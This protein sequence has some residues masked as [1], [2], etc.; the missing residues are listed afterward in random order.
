MLNAAVRLG[1][2]GSMAGKELRAELEQ[3]LGALAIHTEV[4]EHPEVFTV[5]EM[6]PHVQHLK[7]AHSTFLLASPNLITAD[8]EQIVIGRL[9]EDI[10][11]PCSFESEPE[12]VIHW[13]NQDSYVHSYYKGSDHLEAQDHRYTN[14]TSLFHG[15]MHK[16]NASL[17]LRRL[18]L[19]DEGIYLCYVGTTSRT[20]INKVVLKVGAFITPMMKYEKRN[21]E[22]FLICC[23]SSYPHPHISWKMENTT[24]SESNKGEIETLDPL[25]VDSMIN[26]T[27]S[28]LSYECGIENSLLNQTWI[29]RWTLKDDLHK[30]QS[31]DFSLSCELTNSIFLLDQDFIVTWSKVE[32]ETSSIL[33]YFLS[34]SQNTIINEPRVSWNKELINQS[35]FFLTLK[36]L[37]VSDSGE[38]LCNISSSKYT[39]LT[40]QTL[41]VVEQRQSRTTWI[42][43]LSFVI[44]A[45]CI[46]YML[47][48]YKH[49]RRE[50]SSVYTERANTADAEESKAFTEHPASSGK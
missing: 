11:L 32:R 29:G 47:K 33:A 21:T 31:E 35:D 48:R 24:I 13:K 1:H 41:H 22:S 44:L 27:G 50:R 36:D 43:I 46:F 17:S 20:F 25:H 7:G 49:S 6:M 5:E 34:S 37:R 12:V 2:D 16:G 26:I 4:V 42:I 15:E 45:I 14:R 18:S 38:Y 9:G 3:R 28:N 23:V 30:K 39:L 10:I 8:E 19:M 40:T